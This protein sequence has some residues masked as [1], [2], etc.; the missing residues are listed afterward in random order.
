[1]SLV[2]IEIEQS[3][4]AADSIKTGIYKCMNNEE[5]Q[6]AFTNHEPGTSIFVLDT[7]ETF[8][9]FGSKTIIIFEFLCSNKY[10][11]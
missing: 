5:S 7:I 4:R 10:K 1:M 9:L 6:R 11:Q 3:I 2:G 8:F